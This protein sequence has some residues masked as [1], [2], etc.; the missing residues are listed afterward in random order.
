MDS[1]VR[2]ITK[3]VTWRIIASATTFSLTL[4]FFGKA[5]LAMASWLT[6]IET[7]VKIVIYYFHERIWF[8]L[9]TNLNS[10][11]RH[12]AKALTWR[13]IAS[14]T[15]FI[16]ALLLFGGHDD[17]LEKATWIALIE[18]ILKMAFYYAH[19]EFWYRINLGLDDRQKESTP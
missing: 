19:E 1:R 11:M 18:S 3:S 9:S 6:A 12:I 8:K 15:T 2:H 7:S 13:I 16:L 14:G 4:A 5:E 17:A 10:K